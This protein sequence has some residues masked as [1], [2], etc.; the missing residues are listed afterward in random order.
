MAGQ[1]W[2]ERSGG[3][4]S[5]KANAFAIVLSMLLGIPTYW[6]MFWIVAGLLR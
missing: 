4:D 3:V 1:H 2:G 6:A 5:W